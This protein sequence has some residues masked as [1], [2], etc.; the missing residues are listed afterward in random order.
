MV[1]CITNQKKC[2]AHFTLAEREEVAIG[3]EQGK[4]MRFIAKS[5][6][7]SPS[8]VSREV[9]RNSPSIR[10]VKYRGNRAQRRSE[11]RSRIGHAKER[12]ADPFVRRYIESHLVNDGWTP[13]E[14][15]GRLPIDFPG[16]QTN[17]ESIYL[18]IYK[19]R[20]DLIQSLARGH[21]TRHKRSSGKA[22]RKT[23]IT[24][25]VDIDF[26]PAYVENRNTAG[27]WEADT[28]V[29]RQSKAATAVFVERKTRNYIVIKMKDKSALSM[30]LATLKALSGLPPHLLKTITYDNGLE[31]ALHELTNSMLGT[32]SYFCKP[33]HSWEKGSIENRNGILRRYF[34]KK[35]NWQL[36][37]QSKINKVLIKINS[38]PMK[39][40]GYKT[41]NEVFANLS[42]VALAG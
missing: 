37:T 34:P 19:E 28:V 14:I 12:L 35:H 42:G 40:L 2:Y 41:P 29:S 27:H 21:K 30:H 23:K 15:A 22:L 17:Y 18:W 24:G 8:S 25:R 20:R 7:R 32:K 36:T 4:S 11:E 33:Y 1:K 31:N 39:C 13:E 38:T 3:L 10:A 5:L 26:R 6:D 9:G 16:L